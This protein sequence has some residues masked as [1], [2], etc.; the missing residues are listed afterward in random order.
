MEIG[1][2]VED[3]N[4]VRIWMLCNRIFVN[5]LEEERYNLNIGI[6]FVYINKMLIIKI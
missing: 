2:E 3:R 4:E 6:Y 5:L 1:W